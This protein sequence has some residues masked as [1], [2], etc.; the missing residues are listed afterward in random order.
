MKLWEVSPGSEVK[1][2]RTTLGS[3]ERG[4]G[5]FVSVGTGALVV[6]LV[7]FGI[8]AVGRL[9]TLGDASR[10]TAPAWW[11]A[12]IGFCLFVGLI[13]LILET[14]RKETITLGNGLLRY[15]SQLPWGGHRGVEV[16]LDKEDRFEAE[17]RKNKVK[18]IRF[19]QGE[20]QIILAKT[21]FGD[22][23]E[24]LEALQQANS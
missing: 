19:C 1:A 22:L 18:A 17:T 16:R 21:L 20:D 2:S 15:E 23:T 9:A 7:I 6:S 4:V 10:I 11:A 8:D 13:F 3:A 12:L 24:L 14:L 5:R